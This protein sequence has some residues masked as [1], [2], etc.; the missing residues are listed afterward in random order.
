MLD[1]MLSALSPIYPGLDLGTDLP[2][3][4]FPAQTSIPATFPSQAPAPAPIAPPT[5]DLSH[6]QVEHGSAPALVSPN[7]PISGVA[8]STP[9]VVDSAGLSPWS[10]W[11][12]DGTAGPATV[13]SGGVAPAPAAVIAGGDSGGAV[14]MGNGMGNGNGNGNGIG[15][16]FPASVGGMSPPV[17]PVGRMPKSAADVH[18]AVIKP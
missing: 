3:D 17:A 11:T 9:D 8:S 14:G 7:W 6:A 10:A 16:G 18:Y 15:N 2:M 4:P 1:Q 12:R 5:V 13:G